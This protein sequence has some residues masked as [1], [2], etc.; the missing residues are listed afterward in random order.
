MERRK[1]LLGAGGTVLGASALI[2]AGAFSRVESQR[3]VNIQVATDEDA[4]LRMAPLDTP[5]SINHV[6]LDDDGHI[7]IE[8]DGEAERPEELPGNETEP[9]LGD[10][11]NSDSTTWFDGMFELCNQGKEDIDISLDLSEL[12]VA[13]EADFCF[14]SHDP[15]WG[16]IPDPPGPAELC[17]SDRDGD[18]I[19]GSAELSVGDCVWMGLKTDTHGV[20]APTTLVDGT[21]TVIADSPEAGE[22]ID[23]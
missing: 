7:Y 1:F 15:P 22:P 16:E 21:V 23:D 10:G 2:G 13:D 4:Y 18:G 20:S 12:T 11:V 14:Y 17:Y 9:W 6:D 3:Q 5:N 19:V 8:V